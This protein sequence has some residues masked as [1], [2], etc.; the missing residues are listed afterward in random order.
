[1][2]VLIDIAH[3]AHV[4]FYRP[5][6]EALLADG[7]DV[8]I[9][10][11]DKDVTVSLLQASGLA[12]T[13]LPMATPPAG[14]L[15]AA[16][17]LVRRA[18]TLRRTIRRLGTAAVLTRNPSGVIAS[19]G[20][21]AQSIFDTDDGRSVGLH[22]WLARPFADVIT[23]S[24]HDPEGHGSGHRRYAALKAQMFLHPDRFTPDVS[25]RRRYLV[26]DE[27][28][29]VVRFS[30]HD[31]THDR[32]VQGISDHGR[33]AI[34]QRLSQF[35][36]VLVSVEREG[37]R[38]MRGDARTTTVAP[39]DFHHLLAA[40]CLFVGDSQSVAAESAVL[41]IPALRLSSFTDRVFYLRWLESLGLVRNFKPGEEASL[42]AAIEEVLVDPAGATQRSRDRA[43]SLNA[44]A[45]D[46]LSWYAELVRST[47]ARHPLVP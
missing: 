9:V 8:T 45:D 26:D 41:G 15:G 10:A 4:H 30:S 35:G 28:F 34:L 12:F 31:A 40:A 2:N 44:D 29:C 33:R 43:A 19:L 38:F 22:Y 3:P 6:A 1:M 11:R 46:L 21:S 23:S 24:I 20:T 5:I 36:T 32:R 27:R 47:L 18:L 13:V 17:E 42:L 37:L 14:R 25:I 16:R 7:Y 39:E